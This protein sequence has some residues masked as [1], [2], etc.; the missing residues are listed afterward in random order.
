M[1]LF[2]RMRNLWKKDA[3]DQ[4]LDDEL[5]A[6]LEMRADDGIASG[7]SPKDAR[8]DAQKRFG[9]STLMKERTR[10]MDIFAWLE[11]VWQDIRYAARTLRHSPGFTV[12]AVL[13]LALGIGA[14]TA[15]FSVMDALLLHE[16]P[17]QEPQRIVALGYIEDNE[18]QTAFS[19][20]MFKSLRNGLPPATFSSV[21]A[22]GQFWRSNV[23]IHTA[24]GISGGED[25][26]VG[27]VSGN[28]FATMGV[29]AFAGRT[30]THDDDG[31]PGGHPVA[32]ISYS[33]WKRRFNQASAAIGQT[34]TFNDTTYAIVG[35][36]PEGFTGDWVG[37]STDFWIPASMAAQVFPE[38]PDMLSNP[39][40]TGTRIIARTKPGITL[41]TANS[42]AEVVWYQ[43]IAE[44]TPQLN[45]SWRDYYA[46]E[47][48]EMSSFARGYSPE[49]DVFTQPLIILLIIAG[50]VLLIACA[51]IANLL[52]ARSASRQRE[53]TVRVALGA[54]PGRISR[55]LLTESLLLAALGGASGI[56]FSYWGTNAL[57]GFLNSYPQSVGL[58][59]LY[60]ELTVHPNVGILA[61]TAAVCLFTG[62]LF[63]LAP[64]LRARGLSLAPAL[65]QRSGATQT[66]MSRFGLGKGLLVTQV[67]LSLLL[68]VGAG[69][70]VRTLYKLKWQDLGF[71]RQHVL[72]VWTRPG[73]S[74][75]TGP[76]LASFYEAAQERISA[77]PGVVSASPSMKGLLRD[78]PY[79]AK[80]KVPGYIPKSDPDILPFDLVAP[81][82]FETV[83]MRL[84][85][86]RDFTARDRENAAH[87]AVLNEFTARQYFGNQNPIG[88]H[89]GIGKVGRE[90]PVE[91]TEIVGV[92]RD[93]KGYN[94]LR[95]TERRMIYIPFR[96][97]QSWSAHPRIANMCL[98]VR[99]QGD[100]QRMKAAIHA[101]LMRLDPDLPVIGMDSV[102]EQ[103][104]QAAADERII[105]VL[106]TFFGVLGVVLACIGLYG[107]ISYT[108]ARR[109]NEIGIRMALGAHRGKILA[110]VLRES[111]LLVF[112]GILIG[113]PATLAVTRLVSSRLYGI[114]AADPFTIAGAAILMLAVAALAGF[115][116][117]RRASR[118]DPIAAL[119]YE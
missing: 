3:L 85:A 2:T 69:L 118:V 77:L 57:L 72:L 103:L 46:H 15:I 29:N 106:S 22:V 14:N 114:S 64:A 30:L 93:A 70:F 17:V 55:Q 1:S 5:R 58:G 91:D 60:L 34:L 81:R 101:E 97:D 41:R 76:A 43:A 13:S 48:F 119:R 27:L 40:M 11:S 75:T 51:N 109:T 82:F 19:F 90:A 98:A 112:I 12:I 111:L 47:R 4:N 63:G 115:I 10:E 8:Y 89:V 18:Y 33:Y 108:V 61:F 21:S 79:G 88:Q 94:S 65:A 28:F 25:A 50:V 105:A 66:W 107:L 73:Q 96:Q 116:P 44:M 9:N 102:E 117:A 23:T 104:D 49:R 113:V 99:T 39:N 6:H 68:L 80:I 67:G 26:L 95:E 37:R 20:P 83:G 86:G 45:A 92:V 74:R 32:V 31:A 16:L 87:V 42:A 36:A 38:R 78:Q 56:L 110:M 24:A 53:I 84:T 7:L 54:G 100:P 71:D 52:L 62:I 59:N 35:V